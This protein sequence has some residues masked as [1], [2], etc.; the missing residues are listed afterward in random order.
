MKK[1]GLIICLMLVTAF[2]KAQSFMD[3]YTKAYNFYVKNDFNISLKMYAVGHDKKEQ[4]MGEGTMVKSRSDYYTG[5]GDNETYIINHKLI[6]VDHARKQVTYMKDYNAN[7]LK[8]INRSML[9]SSMFQNV[10]S[11]V[12][13]GIKS[14]SKVYRVYGYNSEYDLL[15][16]W[17]DQANYA[18]SKLV[19]MDTDDEEDLEESMVYKRFTVQYSFNPINT[20]SKYI[21]INTIF[22]DESRQILSARFK[23]YAFRE[24]KPEKQ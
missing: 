3:D 9:D 16:I 5:Y 8:T 22:A 23:G 6:T 11:V 24:L 10:D 12:Y 20:N 14:G 7:N 4:Y 17:I 2:V 1:Q 18:V 21:N 13:K 19:Y 15:D